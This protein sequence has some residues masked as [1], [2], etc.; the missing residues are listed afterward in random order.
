MAAL[1]T[2][3]TQGTSDISTLDTELSSIP[4]TYN[5]AGTYTI[6]ITPQDSS[7]PYEWARAFG[8][9][10][11]LYDPS[12]IANLIKVHTVESMPAH[13]FFESA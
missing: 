11:G 13:G 10:L 2:L 4:H 3:G 8:S 7:A 12:F 1:D 5:A 9:G 6:T